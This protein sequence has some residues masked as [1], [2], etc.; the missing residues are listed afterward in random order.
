MVQA[1]NQFWSYEFVIK[2][3]SDFMTKEDDFEN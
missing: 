2:A 3:G 1:L